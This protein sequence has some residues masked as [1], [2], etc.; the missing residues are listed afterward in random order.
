MIHALI[1]IDAACTK[2][3]EEWSKEQAERGAVISQNNNDPTSSTDTA[4]SSAD[5]AAV[6][7]EAI[8]PWTLKDPVNLMSKVPNDWSEKVSIFLSFLC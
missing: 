6:T 5:T 1:L 8:D 4:T 2:A 7:I 3:T